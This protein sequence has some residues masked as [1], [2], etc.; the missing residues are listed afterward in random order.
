MFLHLVGKLTPDQVVSHLTSS[1]AELPGNILSVY[2]HAL[3]DALIDIPVSGA[4]YGIVI[5]ILCALLAAMTT[6]VYA[7]LDFDSDQQSI[8]IILN[9]PRIEQLLTTLLGLFVM[10]VVPNGSS[11]F[12]E[13]NHS[14]LS[15]IL[16]IS[17]RVISLP[18]DLVAYLFPPKSQEVFLGM[19]SIHMFLILVHQPCDGSEVDSYTPFRR[20]LADL[21]DDDMVNTSNNPHIPFQ[22]LYNAIVQVPLKQE[23]P[24]LLMFTLITE[25]TLFC[26]YL[27]SKSDLH[28]Y[29]VEILYHFYNEKD[30]SSNFSYI[31]ISFLLRLSQDETFAKNA[32]S[33]VRV[34]NVSLPPDIY[35]N[36]V[37]LGSYYFHCSPSLIH[38][39]D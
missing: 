25:N 33:L 27:L 36:E 8:K 18:L 34:P 39:L 2:T 5:E 19:Y 38:C 1:T 16:A 14:L 10:D 20:A 15:R 24:L 17:S 23:W 13:E 29:I 6:Q 32:H 30:S 26:D 7:P 11:S 31:M 3:I 22:V 28:H 12:H 37:S 4:T 21:I 35:F 9:H